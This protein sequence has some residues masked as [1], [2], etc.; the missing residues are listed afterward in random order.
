MGKEIQA[1]ILGTRREEVGGGDGE[2]FCQPVVVVWYVFWGFVVTQE[3]GR[4]EQVVEF[5]IGSETGHVEQGVNS[6]LDICGLE[7]AI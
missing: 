5:Y 3:V 4:V 7:A 1:T 6:V 2:E